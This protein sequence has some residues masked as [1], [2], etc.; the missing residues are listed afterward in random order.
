[1]ERVRE[2]EILGHAE[3]VPSSIRSDK[4]RRRRRRRR[5][6]NLQLE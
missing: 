4:T 6:A 5:E 1:M 2:R 3:T